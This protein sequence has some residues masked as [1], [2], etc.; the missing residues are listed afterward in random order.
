M[1]RVIAPKSIKEDLFR[2][3]KAGINPEFPEQG[4]PQG[5]VVSPVLANIALNGIEEIHQSVRYADDLVIILKPQDNA[6]EILEKIRQ[7]LAER[8]M[9]VSERKTKLTATT[10]G[11]DFLGWHFKVQNN[12]KF[13][14]TPSESN[15]KSFRQK[16]KAIVNN[17]AIGSK[18][19]AKLL[20]PLVRGWRNYHRFSKMDGSRF[21]LWRLDNRTY[22]VFLKEP[23]HNRTSAKKLIKKAFPDVGYKENG[24]VNVKGDKSPFDGNLIYWSERNSKLYDGETSKALKKQN[25]RCAA[26]GLKLVG[27]ERIHLHH[28][29]GNR[30]NNRKDNL[31]AV[32]ESC[33]DYLHMR[34]S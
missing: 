32:H 5:G 12:G 25:H 21:S 11:F 23:S 6:E 7:F 17:S 14:C 28:R 27:E 9:N 31:M 30:A 15:Y 16:V 19:K 20:G 18:E 34:K 33:H 4:T 2:C 26:C 1:E 22:K 24:F 8:G 10:D 29:D 3:L 13:R